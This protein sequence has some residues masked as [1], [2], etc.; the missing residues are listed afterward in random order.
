LNPAEQ[1]ELQSR[2]ERKQMKDF[3]NVCAD[4]DGAKCNLAGLMIF[5]DVFE[6]GPAMLQRLRDGFHIQEFTG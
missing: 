1:R 3:M 2:M 4:A 6:S 5:A